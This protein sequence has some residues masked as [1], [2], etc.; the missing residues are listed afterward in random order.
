MEQEVLKLLAKHKITPDPLKDQFF[1]VDET[2]LA[3]MMAVAHIKPHERV[4]EIGPGLGTITRELAQKAKEVVAVEIDPQ[5]KPTLRGLPRHVKV[6]YGHALKTKIKFDKL[7]ASLPYSL[8]EP[9][10]H[11]LVKSYF[12]LLVLILPFKLA[13]KLIYNLPWK[14]FYKT[15]VI[16]PVPKSAFYPQPKTSSVLVKITR[17]PARQA[18]RPVHKVSSESWGC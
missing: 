15:E 9:L 1:L 4:W 5:F 13:Q 14:A 7:V 12:K 11:K 16:A 3:K 6:I 18:R 2:I 17:L 8:A 10:M